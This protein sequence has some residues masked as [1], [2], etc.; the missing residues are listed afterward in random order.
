MT[1]SITGT[2]AQLTWTQRLGSS[3]PH[4]RRPK[5]RMTGF[6]GSQSFRKILATPADPTCHRARA[7]GLPEPLL[8]L[9]FGEWELSS[10][11]SHLIQLSSPFS[12][13]NPNLQ[14]PSL[15]TIHLVPTDLSFLIALS[16]WVYVSNFF[17]PTYIYYSIIIIAFSA[18]QAQETIWGV[19]LCSRVSCYCST[20]QLSS[21]LEKHQ[22]IQDRK[23]S[24]T[25][26]HNSLNANDDCKERRGRGEGIPVLFLLSSQTQTRSCFCTGVIGPRQNCKV[27]KEPAPR[28]LLFFLYRGNPHQ[29][30][31]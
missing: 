29:I 25:G 22:L 8:F 7:S 19:G 16:N 27:H 18:L 2:E 3:S 17:K 13:E 6:S 28:P 30:S 12:A 10:S 24:P 11:F 21:T 9:C 5:R 1:C 4:W 31:M 20:S 26:Q 15:H 14:V 23:P